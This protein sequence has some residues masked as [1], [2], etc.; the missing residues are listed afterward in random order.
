M[1]IS[2]A[3]NA[4]AMQTQRL[5]MAQPAAKADQ[6]VGADGHGDGNHGKGPEPAGTGHAPAV[7]ATLGNHL[8]VT[9]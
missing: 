6:R 2:A 3:N 1:D 7:S 5:G 4:T 8:N 9:A